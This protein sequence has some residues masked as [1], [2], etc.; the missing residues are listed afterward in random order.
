MVI[1]ERVRRLKA[2]GITPY[3]LETGNTDETELLNDA[4]QKINGQRAL[5]EDPRRP[6]R[7]GAR[8]GR[9]KGVRSQERR[10]AI[11]SDAI[12]RRLCQATELSWERRAEILGPPWSAT[13][14]RRH[15]GHHE[16]TP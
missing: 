5:G 4:I 10:D 13:T 9:M 1:V 14:L 16:A 15:Y 11:M 3:D 2:L 6:R 12:V 8:G 7:M